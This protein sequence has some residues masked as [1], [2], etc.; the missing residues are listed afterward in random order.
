MTSL[1]AGGWSVNGRYMVSN[2]R[3]RNRVGFKQNKNNGKKVRF[4]VK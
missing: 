1:L 3:E 4:T 2:K